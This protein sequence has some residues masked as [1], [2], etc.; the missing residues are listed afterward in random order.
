M[1][2]ICFFSFFK[3]SKVDIFAM[4]LILYK[5]SHLNNIQKLS[6]DFFARILYL[7][8]LINKN[9]YLLF[10]ILYASF[11]YIYLVLN[12]KYKKIKQ[13]NN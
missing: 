6:F 1:I 9:K 10:F 12:N 3:S 7:D 11:S 4:S 13:K 2:I 8:L 5:I